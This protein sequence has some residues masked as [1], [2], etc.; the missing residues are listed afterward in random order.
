M[1]FEIQSELLTDQRPYGESIMNIILCFRHVI[2][3]IQKRADESWKFICNYLY[4]RKRNHC[5]SVSWRMARD[6]L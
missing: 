4:Y 6:T 5:H 3:R 1:Q 2:R